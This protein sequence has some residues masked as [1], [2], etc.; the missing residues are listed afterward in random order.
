MLVSLTWTVGIFSSEFKFKLAMFRHSFRLTIAILFA[1]GLG[2]F[3]RS[4]YLLDFTDY[5]CNYASLILAS[6]R[7]KDRIIGT[8][9]AAVAVVL[10]LH[11]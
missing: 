1:Y 7:S 4:K 8:F 3:L 10:I 6:E 11:N 2:I 9:G 5:H